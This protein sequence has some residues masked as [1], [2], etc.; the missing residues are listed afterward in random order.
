MFL[1]AVSRRD[2]MFVEVRNFVAPGWE[3]VRISRRRM[4]RGRDGREEEEGAVES[5]WRVVWFSRGM[6][7][8]VGLF[9]GGLVAEGDGAGEVGAMKTKPGLGTGVVPGMTVM[10]VAMLDNRYCCVVGQWDY[11]QMTVTRLY[12]W[13]KLGDD[14]EWLFISPRDL[15]GGVAVPT[16]MYTFTH[17]C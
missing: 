16:S 9:V 8:G 2:E 11:I 10:R 1:T 7:E 15:N 17:P 6:G 14:V 12:S 5:S 4:G 13:Y 3:R